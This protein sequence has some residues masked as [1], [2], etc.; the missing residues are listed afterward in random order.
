MRMGQKASIVPESPVLFQ[1]SIKGLAAVMMPQLRMWPSFCLRIFFKNSVAGYV[2][3]EA[4][5]F[6][7]T[8]DQNQTQQET[9]MNERTHHLLSAVQ[10][11]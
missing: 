2:M 3:S 10:E 11:A 5:T 4:D 1:K 6:F 8:S 9:K 7:N